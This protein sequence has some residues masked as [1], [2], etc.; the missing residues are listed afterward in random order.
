MR[1]QNLLVSSHCPLSAASLPSRPGDKTIRGSDYK[2][3]S[4][5]IFSK[6]NVRNHSDDLI[7]NQN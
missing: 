7:S 6:N 1:P 2:Y 3:G 4:L 5:G